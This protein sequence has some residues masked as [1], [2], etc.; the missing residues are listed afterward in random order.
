M[1]NN[2]QNHLES[3]K[4]SRKRREMIT[5]LR[6]EIMLNVYLDI[7]FIFFLEIFL[8]IRL[9]HICCTCATMHTVWCLHAG[10]S[11]FRVRKRYKVCKKLNRE[12]SS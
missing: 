9:W 3:H 11:Q 7:F 12:D 8:I 6:F 2:V 1:Y 5:F 10:C 4:E